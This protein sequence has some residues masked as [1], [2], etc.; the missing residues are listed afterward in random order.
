MRFRKSSSTR[1]I[2]IV[3]IGSMLLASATHSAFAN[4]EIGE[5]PLYPYL[6]TNGGCFSYGTS[7]SGECSSVSQD[8]TGVY[9]LGYAASH[10]TDGTFNGGFV[11]D[12]SP[13]YSQIGTSCTPDAHTPTITGDKCC[14]VFADIDFLG[15]MAGSGATSTGYGSSAIFLLLHIYHVEQTGTYCYEL[16]VQDRLQDWLLPSSRQHNRTCLRWNSNSRADR[17]PHVW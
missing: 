2:L 8:S 14:T 4:T 3:I 17:L 7:G 12:P 5:K 10:G 15:E 1:L 13:C 6:Q 11:T 16:G 9:G